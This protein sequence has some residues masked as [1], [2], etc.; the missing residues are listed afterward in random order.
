MSDNIPDWA[1]GRVA[2]LTGNFWP[3]DVAARHRVSAAFARYISE[4]EQPPVDPVLDTLADA[5]LC[6]FEDGF[7][8]WAPSIAEYAP[9]LRD[10][11]ARRGIE[12]A[13]GGEK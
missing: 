9:K 10:E 4:H 11:L 5:M 2:D 3:P 6:V 8:S 1:F 7:K 13:T 12:I